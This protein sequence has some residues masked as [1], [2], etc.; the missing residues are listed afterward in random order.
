VKL[1]R[2]DTLNGAGAALMIGAAAVVPAGD[3]GGLKTLP[4]GPWLKAGARR[5]T[6]RIP[7]VVAV[8][9]QFE[10]APTGTYAEMKRALAL[11][12]TAASTSPSAAAPTAEAAWLPDVSARI[13]ELAA[14]AQEEGIPAPSGRTLSFAQDA[15]S[16]CAAVGVTEPA[17]AHDDEG[18][19]EIYLKEGSSALLIAIQANDVLTVFGDDTQE[20]WRSRY[21]LSGSAWKRHLA[22]L[23]GELPLA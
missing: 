1:P 18:G 17:V 4:A 6:V 13:D 3:A 5:V 14:E 22:R 16:I 9:P 10:I 19:I 15:I 23:A 7:Q 20:Q 11:Y 21:L 2:M 8:S 12:Q